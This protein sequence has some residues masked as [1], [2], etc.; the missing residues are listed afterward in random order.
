MGLP[1]SEYV[2]EGEEG[3]YQKS[4]EFTDQAASLKKVCYSTYPHR[5]SYKVTIM[6]PSFGASFS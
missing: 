1:R 6:L 3:T 5:Y 4:G 2:Q